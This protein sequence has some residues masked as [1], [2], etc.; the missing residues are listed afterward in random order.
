[1]AVGD[2]ELQVVDGTADRRLP[3]FHRGH[4]RAAR[5][6]GALRRAIVVH[7]PVRGLFQQAVEPVAAREHGGQGQTGR[8]RLPQAGLGLGRGQEREGHA[9][10]R[11]PAQEVRRRSADGLVRQVEAR[12]GRQIRPD[13]P[14]RSV[15]SGPGQ[16]GGPVPRRDAVRPLVPGDQVGQTGVGEG[17]P[18]GT[19]GRA[20]SVDDVRETLG[21]PDGRRRAAAAG[22]DRL[23]VGIDPHHVRRRP[24][25][26]RREPLVDDHGQGA[27]I[28]QH[29]VQTLRRGG[30]VQG[31]V[32]AAGL[33][34][35]QDGHHQIG[36]ALEADAHHRLRSGAQRAQMARQPV[37]P[38]VQLAI[39]QLFPAHGDRQGVRGLQ[40][41]GLEAL[42]HPGEGAEVHGGVVPLREQLH[43]LGAGEQLQ[44]GERPAGAGHRL[45]QLPFEMAHQARDGR[46]IE[47]VAVVERHAPQTVGQVPEVNFQVETGGAPLGSQ[48]AQ[49][50]AG[51]L[52]RAHRRVLQGE[53]HLEQGVAAQAAL[54]LQLLDELLERQILV[55][56]GLEGRLAD[57][58]QELPEGRIAVEAGRAA[59]GC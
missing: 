2:I 27:G 28:P 33:D 41:P 19:A 7:Q 39:A 25:H 20:R 34:R 54:R 57:A 42:A 50:E 31:E 22:G 51:E 32:G 23:P 53:H 36:G 56:V 38:E 12:A 40:H 17:H 4:R 13:L 45:R 5:D 15:E 18:L 26:R 47:Q 35:R 6:H 30:R 49:G 37:G 14:H 48:R 44:L 11:E 3:V 43:P 55:G 10:R 16:L 21:Q 1:M 52:E 29:E 46:G 59:P 9:R 58:G 24:F 8:R